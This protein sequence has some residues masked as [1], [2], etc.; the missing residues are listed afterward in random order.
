ME[1]EKFVWN[2]RMYDLYK[3][4]L[5][6]EQIDV[7]DLFLTKGLQISEIAELKKTSRQ[8]VSKNV[9]VALEKLQELEK[10]LHFLGFQDKIRCEISNLDKLAK[11]GKFE[12]LQK[13]LEILKKE[14]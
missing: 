12:D 8:A 4:C 9:K 6:N 7:L 13:K 14:I 1:L 5:S 2:S 10:S 3:D 11:N